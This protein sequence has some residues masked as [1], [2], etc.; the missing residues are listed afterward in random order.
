MRHSSF[1]WLFLPIFLVGCATSSTTPSISPAP[2]AE[3]FSTLPQKKLLAAKQ[4]GL[5][6]ADVAA[7]TKAALAK[8]DFLMGRPLYVAP[9]SKAPFDQAFTNYMITSLVNAGVRVTDNPEVGVLLKYETQVIPH[10]ISLDLANEGFTPV[11]TLGTAWGWVMRNAFVNNSLRLGVAGTLTAAAALD[12]MRAS[13]KKL[14]PTDV[15]LL[16]TTSIINNEQYL[17]RSTDAYYIEKADA[18][19]FTPPPDPEMIAKEKAKPR[20]SREWKVTQ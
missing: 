11:F 6:A 3:A 12:Y 20:V 4:W 9:F 15:E 16:I 10:K 13:D 14:S 17:Q 18:E 19:L 7:Q 5:I 8:D 2:V 1:R